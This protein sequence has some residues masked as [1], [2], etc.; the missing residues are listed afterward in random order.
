MR[1]T[2]A[3]GLLRACY[4][5]ALSGLFPSSIL[6]PGCILQFVC[7]M[8]PGDCVCVCMCVYIYCSPDEL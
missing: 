4:L 7:G 5:L 8:I 1:C 3:L 2:T 6:S